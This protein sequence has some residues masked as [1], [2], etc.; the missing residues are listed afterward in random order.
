[1]FASI[2]CKVTLLE[3]VTSGPCLLCTSP[4]RIRTEDL[5][6][7]DD[8]VIMRNKNDVMNLKTESQLQFAKSQ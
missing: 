3:R 2:N 1:M 6:I 5:N 8:P 4:A 7:K